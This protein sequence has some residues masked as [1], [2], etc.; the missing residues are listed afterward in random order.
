MRTSCLI[1]SI[2]VG[3]LILLWL[4]MTYPY[5][6]EN[7]TIR[8]GCA[9]CCG[10][11]RHTVNPYGTEFSCGIICSGS[12]HSRGY[13]EA[14]GVIVTMSSDRNGIIDAIVDGVKK[15][16]ASFS[17]VVE[18]SIQN[19]KLGALSETAALLKKL[20]TEETPSDPDEIHKMSKDEI[21]ITIYRM[22]LFE[23]LRHPVLDDRQLEELYQRTVDLWGEAP[24]EPKGRWA[25]WNLWVTLHRRRNGIAITEVIEGSK[26]VED[27]KSHWIERHQ[28]REERRK[29]HKMQ[30]Y[31]RYDLPE[32]VPPGIRQLVF[33]PFIEDEEELP[34][35]ELSEEPVMEKESESNKR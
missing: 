30:N 20:A 19:S 12:G 10:A 25:E 22:N 21:V 23:K 7:K 1:D 15:D 2:R 5:E 35:V 4:V 26:K 29:F 9:W 8:L 13:C 32:D 28:A 16:D 11:R 17:D 34:D 3:A 6:S 27:L 14:S 33:N 31:D 18:K 24:T